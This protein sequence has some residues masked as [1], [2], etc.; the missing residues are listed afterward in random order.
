M[1]PCHVLQVICAKELREGQRLL[2]VKNCNVCNREALLM[3]N[4]ALVAAQ[5]A[6]VKEGMLR[7]KSQGSFFYWQKQCLL[8]SLD[9]SKAS[10]R[11]DLRKAAAKEADLQKKLSLC[12][13]QASW[14]RSQLGVTEAE[15]AAVKVEAA[16]LHARLQSLEANIAALQGDKQAADDATAAQAAVQEA[17]VRVLESKIAALLA[18]KQAADDATAAQAAVQEAN[19]RVLE[20]KTAVLLADKQAADDAA[21][22]QAAVQVSQVRSLEDRIAA[23]QAADDAA[24]T[25]ICDMQEQ[26]TALYAQQHER[27]QVEARLHH[28]LQAAT[29]QADRDSQALVAARQQVQDLEGTVSQLRCF[30]DV[31]MPTIE[32]KMQNSPAMLQQKEALRQLERDVVVSG[33]HTMLLDHLPPAHARRYLSAGG[34]GAVYSV[35]INSFL[36]QVPFSA[37]EGEQVAIKMVPV[38]NYLQILCWTP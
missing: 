32:K 27:E 3:H 4:E 19:V 11:S 34:Y 2:A 29:M 26:M 25:Q 6:T 9:A 15:G 38:S 12:Q 17:N 31:W 37:S 13:Q 5:H 35:P 33:A 22:A 18:D 36:V 8:Q 20:S 1:R 30:V 10:H 21:A 23:M 7:L 14:L 28:E 24:A 16:E